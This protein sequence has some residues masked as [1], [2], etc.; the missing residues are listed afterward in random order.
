MTDK[1]RW[2]ARA[3]TIVVALILAAVGVLS[4]RGLEVTTEIT[5]FV[6]DSD[7]RELAAIAAEMSRSDLSR[8]ITLLV[9]ADD[10]ED[11]RAAAAELTEGLAAIDDVAWARSAVDEHFEEAFY[12][13]Y[14][15]RRLS[16]VEGPLDEAALTDDVRDLKRR[17]LS[18]T[19][20]FIR[21]IAPEDPLMS[22]VHLLERLRTEQ[23]GGLEVV[24]GQ[25]VTSDGAAV[26][27]LASRSSPFDGVASRAL[28]GRIDGLIRELAEHHAGLA[29][30]QSGVHRLAIASEDAIR[31]DVTRI[32]VV[33]TIGVILLFVILFRSPRY[34]ALAVVPL[35]AGFVLALATCRLAFGSI[36]GLSLAFGATLIGVAI[37]YVAH[38]LNHHLL[39]P[40]PGGAEGTLRR[41]WPG[42]ALGAATTIAGLAGLAWTSFPGIREL[43]VF[44]SVGVL[45]ALL[46]TRYLLPPWMPD[47]PTATKLHARMADA[48]GRFMERMER[49][50]RPLLVIPMIAL[51]VSVVGI[52][53]VEWTDDI[54][55]LNTLDESLAAEDDRVRAAVSRMDAGRFVIAWGDN[56]EEA[57]R[58]NDEVFQR[59]SDATEAGEV[60]RF[61]SIHTLLPSAETQRASVARLRDDAELIARLDR[62]LEAEGF[63]PEMFDA[64]EEAIGEGASDPLTWAALS[65]SPLGD[66]VRPF[67]IELSGGRTAFITLTRGADV[68][69][70][71]RRLEGIEGVRLFDQTRFLSGA[72]GRFRERTLELILA[73]LIG[74]FLLVFAR[75]RAFWPAV[76]AFLPAVLAAS[77]ALGVIVLLGYPTSLMH[78][79]ALLLVLSMGVDYGVFMVE[80]RQH[81]GEGGVTVVG[82]LI[83]CIST[84]L[85]FGLLAMSVNPA[86]R[87]LGLVSAIGVGMSLVLA[88]LAWLLLPN[89]AG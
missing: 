47:A 49:S 63:V 43:A 69:A 64:F 81:P 37:D 84:V 10:P 18:P 24:D 8:S 59:L 50:R 73:G 15:E 79:V 72:Y 52:A 35:G 7:D 53:R 32:S 70:L 71:E 80:S 28:E 3:I 65:D 30:E 33:S 23:Q 56:E 83:A 12:A 36:H 44:T 22:F 17:L 60:G 27:F 11:A 21:T 5:E 38:A 16:F 1:A 55:S 39:A 74:V 51:V 41:I 78:L 45:G 62:A 88:P 75:Y 58:R 67:R 61:R 29:V 6:P 76:A 68:D 66:M 4:F 19:G 57:L 25:L 2:R 86:L 13:L 85:S 87:A 9:R 82:L 31:A 14:F 48:V 46:A 20:T 77:S 26:V 89:R 54:R 40:A 42:L 34:L